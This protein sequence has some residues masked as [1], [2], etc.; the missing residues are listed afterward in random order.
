LYRAGIES[1]LGI[2]LR[3]RSLVLDPCIPSGWPGYR[4]ELNLR[5]ARYEIVVENP[6]GTGRGVS[7]LTV[8]G[9]RLPTEPSIVPLVDDGVHRV[10]V[11]LGSA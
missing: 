10:H 6:H 3:G 5:S 9:D 2:Q 4:V 11:T 8:D 1:I 7:A